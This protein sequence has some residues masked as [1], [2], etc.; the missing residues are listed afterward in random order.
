L[1]RRWTLR[2]TTYSYRFAEEVLNAKLEIKKEIEDVVS[3]IML[4]T[5]PIEAGDSPGKGTKPGVRPQ[6]NR[7]FEGEFEKRG[8]QAEFRVF[9]DPKSPMAKID[10]MKSRVGVEVAFTHSSFLGIDLLKFQMLSYSELDKIDVGVYIVPT[11]E[12]P[13]RGFEGSLTFDKVIK[14]LPHLRSAIQVP[15]WVIGL[16]P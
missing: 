1:R 11:R 8:W 14:Y 7:L 12:L 5:A 4:Q 16:L 13:S 15:I 10:F 9:D 6:M 3:S 2:F